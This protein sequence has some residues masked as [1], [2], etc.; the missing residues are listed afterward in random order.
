VKYAIVIGM[1]LLA[2]GAVQAAGAPPLSVWRAPADTAWELV[3]GRG[4]VERRGDVWVWD[5]K[6]VDRGGTVGCRLPVAL[7]DFDEIRLEYKP[8]RGPVFLMVTSDGFPDPELSRNWYDKHPLKL[9]DWNSVALAL[10]LDDDGRPTQRPDGEDLWLAFLYRPATENDDPSQRTVEFRNVRLVRHPVAWGNDYFRTRQGFRNGRYEIAY[11]I[12]L[13]NRM[14]RPVKVRLSL[15]REAPRQG[16]PLFE[17]PPAER[18]SWDLQPFFGAPGKDAVANWG[19]G[20]SEMSGDALPVWITF[21]A[22]AESVRQR[23]PLWTEIVWPQLEVEGFAEPIL[24][25]HS[26]RIDP[27]FLVV[28]PREAHHPGLEATPATL[29]RARRRNADNPQFQ[30]VL[31]AFVAHAERLLA[32]PYVERKPAADDA[33]V[34]GEDWRNEIRP[35]FRKL[36][37]VPRQNYTFGRAK[38]TRC[39]VEANVHNGRRVRDLARAYA[40]TGREDF[41]QAALDVFNRYADQYPLWEPLRESTTAFRSRAAVNTL[42]VGFFYPEYY[43][44]YDY[45]RNTLSI[46][47]R[48]RIEDRFL[49]PMTRVADNHV[50]MYSNQ[51]TVHNLLPFFWGMLSEN[52]CLGMRYAEGP[53]GLYAMRR[54]GFDADGMGME[55]DMGY[56]WNALDPMLRVAITLSL[57]GYDDS[58]LD[59]ESLLSTPIAL[60]PNPSEFRGGWRY[61]WAFAKYGEPSYATPCDL[62]NNAG[63]RSFDA[64][65]LGADRLPAAGKLAFAPGHLKHAG[66]VVVRHRLPGGGLRSLSTNY[67]S[68]HHRS[69]VDRL[70]VHVSEDGRELIGMMGQHS[71][72]TRKGWYSTM[73]DSLLAVN[74]RDQIVGRGRLVRLEQRQDWAAVEVATTPATALYEPNVDYRRLLVSGPDFVVLLDRA[75]SPGP[76]AFHWAFYPGM[77]MA[78]PADWKQAPHPGLDPGERENGPL[79]PVRQDWR[80]GPTLV[81]TLRLNAEVRDEPAMPVTV[82]AWPAQRP[83]AFTTPG[84]QKGGWINALLLHGP[85]L[86]E[87]AWAAVLDRSGVGGVTASWLPVRTGADRQVRTGQAAA[88]RVTAPSGTWTI[89]CA[90]PDL[91]ASVAPGGPLENGWLIRK[92]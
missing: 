18:C 60:A 80:A 22:P 55:H 87:A 57:Y 51:L 9:N 63:K 12:T 81:E 53:R 25:L 52:W 8:T 86:Q 16:A 4:A 64:L 45:L 78:P 49:L 92:H 67:G 82:L 37:Y 83:L 79:S 7:A 26:S 76:A 17:L 29:E 34:L 46:D 1:G 43:I 27:W 30:G 35:Q 20:W 84:N 73:A 3:K 62:L 31:D 90:N 59:L 24:P 40:L 47:E 11:P 50:N 77:D 58:G 72:Y 5:A 48:R 33:K 65:L 6:P 74:G 61:E 89:A 19:G 23:T 44:G 21:S 66:Y 32:I 38:L 2:A 91:K 68:P 85:A 42:M 70:S 54:H 14:S 75:V 39:A 36:W 71:K 56:H 69:H 13:R 10:A 28:P 88:V 15:R 41:R